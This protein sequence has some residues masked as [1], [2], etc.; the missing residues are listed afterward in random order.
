VN[1][2]TIAVEE[3]FAGGRLL[4]TRENLHERAFAC[5]IFADESMDFALQELK[6]HSVERTDAPESFGEVF[7]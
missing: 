6:V 5:S 2:N 1:A 3:Q 7:E 4:H